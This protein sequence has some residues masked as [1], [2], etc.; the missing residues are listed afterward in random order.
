MTHEELLQR[1]S[2]TPFEYQNVIWTPSKK[3][4]R[5]VRL[6][7][8]FLHFIAMTLKFVQTIPIFGL[9]CYDWNKR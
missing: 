4:W 1:D 7:F 3:I 9:I 2:Y 8:S 6:I 5:D